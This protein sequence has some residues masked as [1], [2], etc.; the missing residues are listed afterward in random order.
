GII[1]GHPFVDSDKRTAVC[2]AN[3]Y[4]RAMGLPGLAD[5]GKVGAAYALTI[6][7]SWDSFRT[8][9]GDRRRETTTSQ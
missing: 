7:L 2:I 9:S 1:K 8:T 4:R 6:G 3:E 5:G